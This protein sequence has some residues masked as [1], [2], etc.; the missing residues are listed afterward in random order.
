VVHVLFGS[1]SG[2]TAVGDQILHQ[3]STGI[4]GEAES[5]DDFGSVLT[6]GDFDCDEYDDLVVGVPM[7]DVSGKAEAGAV[8]VLYGS[9]GGVS[10]V[11]DFYRQG[12]GGVNGVSEE[13]DHFGASLL[14]ANFNGD[15][16][17]G[18]PCLDL[19]IGVPDEEV[20]SVDGAGRVYVYFWAHLQAAAPPPQCADLRAE[21]DMVL[22]RLGGATD[23]APPLEEEPAIEA[24]P[25]RRSAGGHPGPAPRRA[26][27]RSCP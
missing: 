19:A 11:N 5:E 23:D 10:T 25:S 14:A 3:D 24:P 9:S 15:D 21:R 16:D 2:L 27:G 7:E 26:R 4:S 22:A 1:S 12:F 20:L 18:N 6:A 17:G 13:P 8:H